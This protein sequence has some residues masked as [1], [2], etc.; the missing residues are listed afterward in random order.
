MNKSSFIYY[1]KKTRV[2]HYE[3]FNLLNINYIG[4]KK[5]RYFNITTPRN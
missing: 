5:H 3:T 1:E 4:M 2:K